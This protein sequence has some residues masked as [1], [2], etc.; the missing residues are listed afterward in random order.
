MKKI[1]YSIV[2]I[3]LLFSF[4]GC[5]RQ[6]SSETDMISG[7]SANM[8]P[9]DITV[10]I[11]ES[12]RE[13]PALT[14]I[15]SEDADF[16]TW[17]SDYYFIQTEKVTDG[18][19]CYADG[20]EAG[21]IAVLLMADEKDCEAAEEALTEYIRNRAGVFEGYAPQQAAMVKEGIVAVNGRYV[22]LL[23]CPEPQTAK[24]AFLDCFDTDTKGAGNGAEN[25]NSTGE[26]AASE[27]S[28]ESEEVVRG[29]GTEDSY[30]AEAVLQAWRTG[31]DSSLSEIDSSILEAAKD[32]IASEIDDTMSDYEKELA[33]HDFITGWSNF[34]YGV[35]G[36]SSEDGFTDGSNTPYGVLIDRSAMCHGYSSTFQLFMD[37]LDIE[38]ITV[39]GTPGSNGVQHSWNMVKL[40][41]E[42]YCVDCAWDDPIGGSPGHN[43]FNVTSDDL[44]K[45]S[46]H[47]WDESLVPEATGTTYAYGSR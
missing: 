29:A 26:N 3:L 10:A 22:A 7:E 31:D 28:S 30:N 35:F 41:G 34:D 1:I 23:I 14:Q 11:V 5:S 17:L 40:D 25:E 42:W 9:G 15:T 32:V 45:G 37:M 24:K 4:T 18:A 38:C 16:A 20:V 2:T 47:R 39:F 44:R 27:S 8:A 21:E 13:L 43:Y 46:I 6:Q 36:R 19:V 33:I 12:Q